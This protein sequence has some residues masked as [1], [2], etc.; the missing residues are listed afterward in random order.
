[1]KTSVNGVFVAGDIRTKLV[2]QVVTAAADGA[3]A[4]IMAEKYV[5][6]LDQIHH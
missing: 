1:M 6:S 3:I 4:G 2:R 5:N